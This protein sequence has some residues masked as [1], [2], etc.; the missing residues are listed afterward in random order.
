MDESKRELSGE[1]A[2][3]G[4]THPGL[5]HR[6]VPST[7]SA[8]VSGPDGNDPHLDAWGARPPEPLIDVGTVGTVSGRRCMPRSTSERIRSGQPART[9]PSASATITADPDNLW[10]AR[11]AV[12]A[13]C[14][15]PGI[16]GIGI[17]ETAAHLRP[18]LE[19]HQRQAAG[20][21]VQAASGRRGRIPKPGGGLGI[22]NTTNR[23]IQQAM[24]Q[25]L[26]PIV[27]PVFGARS[28]G[29]RPRR[30]RAA[31]SDN[32]TPMIR[33]P[34]RRLVLRLGL[35][36]QVRRANRG[37]RRDVVRLL[38][39]IPCGGVAAVLDDRGSIGRWPS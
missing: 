18:P 39:R 28:H 29:Y 38:L 17:R 15:A 26:S 21:D 33:I 10:A 19:Q 20:G 4:S 1:P 2:K 12:K 8:A 37:R 30:S 24:H 5:P 6:I 35:D 34:V 9:A 3:L 31:N 36:H 13:N 23:L 7:F 27:E 16:R 22:P 11:Q 25:K 32:S 14:G